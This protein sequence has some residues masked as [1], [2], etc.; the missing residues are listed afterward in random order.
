MLG[1]AWYKKSKLGK[2]FWEVVSMGIILDV[3][4]LVI[5]LIF[6]IV[7]AKKGFVKSVFG[8]I[9]T[10]AS[11]AVALLFANMVVDATGGL[12][13]LEE[14]IHSGVLEFLSGI[15][16]FDADISAEGLRATLEGK[17]PEFAID[18][19]VEE[20]GIDAPAG[21][22]IA[23]QLSTPATDFVTFVIAAIVLFIVAKIV[24]TIV[25]VLL[26]TLIEN[27]ALVN[28]LDKLLGFVLGAVE[29][30]LI[31]CIIF[32]LLSFAPIEGITTFI[33]SAMYVDMFYHNNPLQ[34]LLGLVM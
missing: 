16:G 31:V 33:D 28:A 10:I 32:M 17:L 7:S 25:K 3:A 20:Y 13:G 34:I 23:M 4:V 6:A 2:N 30:A 22:T 11:L 29:G 14:T 8:F 1:K 26:T 5:V 27:L 24:L 12:F 15:E 21:T 19:I 18:A 9:M